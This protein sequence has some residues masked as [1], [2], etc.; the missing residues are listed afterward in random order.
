MSD[1]PERVLISWTKSGNT[2]VSS[3]ASAGLIADCIGEY[4][5]ADAITPAAA[6]K[7]PEIAALVE[8]VRI[9]SD[10]LR[11]GAC[12]ERGVIVG[13]RLAIALRALAGEAGRD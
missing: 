10:L 11:S 5:R 13:K 3:Q 12:Y 7:V 6:A 8:V 2:R 4:I 9:Q 1:A